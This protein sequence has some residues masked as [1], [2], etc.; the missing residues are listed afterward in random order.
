M[1]ARA[2]W[3]LRREAVV[4]RRDGRVG[5]FAVDGVA[6]GSASKAETTDPVVRKSNA[7]LNIQFWYT[8]AATVQHNVAGS[9]Q[10]LDS[11]L[12][13]TN[14]LYVRAQLLSRTITFR[15]QAITDSG[16]EDR[17]GRR[18][19]SICN[20]CTYVRLKTHGYDSPLVFRF[21]RLIA[22]LCFVRYRSMIL[23]VGR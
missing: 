11:L 17:R 4:R 20:L 19:C 13:R 7:K 12:R 23:L 5:N 21:S 18:S 10:D 22:L 3:R 6:G 1:R 9:A 16:F 8:T 15:R 2:R 14:R